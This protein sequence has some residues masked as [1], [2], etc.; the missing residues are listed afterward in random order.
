MTRAAGRVK[1]K[2]SAILLVAEVVSWER[3]PT[4][5]KVRDEWGA[6]VTVISMHPGCDETRSFAK[7]ANEW[8]TRH[9]P[10]MWAALER[11]GGAA[12]SLCLRL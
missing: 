11:H 1:R 2:V 10:P 5:R 7:Y 8:G 4:H 12:S 9:W 3:K 6:F